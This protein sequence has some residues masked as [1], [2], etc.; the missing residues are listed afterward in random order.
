MEM[1][2]VLTGYFIHWEG[3]AEL[4]QWLNADVG[5]RAHA[6]PC[7]CFSVVTIIIMVTIKLKKLNLWLTAPKGATPVN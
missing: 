1:Q 6:F 2:A 4:L 7:A 5:I 3:K